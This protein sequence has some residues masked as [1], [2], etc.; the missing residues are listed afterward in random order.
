MR[1]E[2][3]EQGGVLGRVFR[4]IPQRVRRSPEHDDLVVKMLAGVLQQ[5]RGV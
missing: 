3:F 4:V 2:G 1:C 5:C